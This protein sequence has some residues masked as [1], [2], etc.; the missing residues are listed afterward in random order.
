MNVAIIGAGLIG[1]KRAAS[2]D[3][4]DKLVIVCD[5]ESY[6]AKHLANKYSVISTQKVEDI[7]DSEIDIVIISVVNKYAMEIAV[8]ILLNYYLSQLK[9]FQ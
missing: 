4:S 2:L 5:K 8:K 9:L 1:N 3:K 6:Q 7:I